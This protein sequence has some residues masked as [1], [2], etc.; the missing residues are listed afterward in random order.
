M[1]NIKIFNLENHK[2]KLNQIRNGHRSDVTEKKMNL[3]MKAMN[4]RTHEY[5]PSMCKHSHPTYARKQHYNRTHLKLYI[6]ISGCYN[7]THLTYVDLF[8]V[9]VDV[10]QVI[11]LKGN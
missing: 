10:A 9:V 2:F 3:K 11:R 5:H 4:S 6:K 7:R 1:N 8:L